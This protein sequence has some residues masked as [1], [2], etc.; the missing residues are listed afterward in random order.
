MQNMQN[1][2]NMNNMNNRSI[3]KPNLNNILNKLKSN[4]PY[5][6][7]TKYDDL[8]SE[9]IHVSDTIDSDTNITDI[10]INSDIKKV[11]KNR[12]KIK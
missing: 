4:I 2:Q 1:M 8:T 7:K 3:K 9:R 11:K 5:N 6:I 12:L 10:N